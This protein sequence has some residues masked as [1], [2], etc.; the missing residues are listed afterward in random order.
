[1]CKYF[2]RRVRYQASF[3]IEV[4]MEVQENLDVQKWNM[5]C[6]YTSAGSALGWLLFRTWTTLEECSGNAKIWRTWTALW[7]STLYQDRLALMK[8]QSPHQALGSAEPA[9]K[10]HRPWQPTRKP[11]RSTSIV[12]SNFLVDIIYEA[13]GRRAVTTISKSVAGHQTVRLWNISS[14]KWWGW[15]AVYR[16]RIF[17]YV[18][19]KVKLCM[20]TPILRTLTPYSN[21][22]PY[23]AI[24]QR[25][26]QI[27]PS[28]IFYKYFIS[29]NFEANK[30]RSGSFVQLP[31]RS[32]FTRRI[33]KRAVFGPWNLIVQK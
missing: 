15:C 18:W 31:K 26:S 28:K 14:V 13:E 19:R 23:M 33:R 6:L 4:Q 29:V 12:Y 21:Y 25:S 24:C 32:T 27:R 2:P 5:P 20:G 1:M 9:S 3:D 16:L 17:V 22:I 7:A 30:N 11:C 8:S 10:H